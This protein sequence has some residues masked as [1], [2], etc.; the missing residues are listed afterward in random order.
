MLFVDDN[1]EN[2]AAAERCGWR[3][4]HFTDAPRLAAELRRL[5]LL[6]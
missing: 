1:A 2:V 6:G 3:A 4:H 5:G